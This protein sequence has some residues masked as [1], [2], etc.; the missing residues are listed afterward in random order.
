M[1]QALPGSRGYLMNGMKGS[2]ARQH[3]REPVLDK[4]RI[5]S[6]DESARV[7]HT[8]EFASI[9]EGEDDTVWVLVHDPE[10]RPRGRD[11]GVFVELGE[12]HYEQNGLVRVADRRVAKDSLERL[13]Y[14]LA[15]VTEQ[16]D[17]NVSQ[18]SRIPEGQ[19]ATLKVEHADAHYRVETKGRGSHCLADMQ[20]VG[21]NSWLVMAGEEP[22]LRR[23]MVNAMMPLHH[24]LTWLA[25]RHV[26]KLLMGVGVACAFLSFVSVVFA[27]LALISAV[28]LGVFRWKQPAIVA[29]THRR[30]VRPH[31]ERTFDAALLVQEPS[32]TE[33]VS[34][35]Y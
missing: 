29:W 20:A 10:R 21:E 17:G 31:I 25:T 5:V 19:Y 14:E 30:V 33:E 32:V 7:V 23:A 28:S 34:V 12:V 6:G 1:R 24:R 27:P 18:R 16:P 22:V 9:G 35:L 15:G 8:T 3:V 4:G 26:E 13:V 11:P 2:K